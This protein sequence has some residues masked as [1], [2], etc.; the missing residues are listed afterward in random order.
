MEFAGNCWECFPRAL[1]KRV[2]RGGDQGIAQL[3][4]RQT[5]GAPHDEALQQL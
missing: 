5:Y 1:R 4:S 3:P 2:R